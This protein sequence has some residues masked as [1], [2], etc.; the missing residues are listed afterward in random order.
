[1]TDYRAPTR[2]I[3]FTLQEVVDAGRVRSLP[4]CEEFEA[5]TVNAVIEE[6]GRFASEVLGPL[7]RSG[8]TEGA[9]WADGEVTTPVGFADA[10][11]QFV[12]AGWNSLTGD[13]DWGGMG[14][15]GLLGAAAHELWNGANMSFALCPLLS[16]SGIELLT[17][18]GSDEQK[19]T[20]LAK[21]VSGEWPGTMDL[22]EPQAGSDLGALR[23]RAEPDGEAYRLFGQKI[24]ITW[25]E[26]DAADNIVHLVLA[27]LPDAPPGV[28]GISLFLVPKYLVNED[29]GIGERNDMRCVSIEHKL[30]IH[31]SPTCTMVYGENDGAVGYLVG[32]AHRGLALMFTMM[33]AARQK[34]GVQALGVAERAYQQARDFALERVQGKPPDPDAPEGAA[35]AYHPDVRRMLLDMKSR[36]EAMRAL[37]YQSAADMD[38]GRRHPDAATRATA[39]ARADLL[40]PVVKAWCTELG[41]ELA[42]TGIQVYGGMG[43]IEETGAAQLL[44]DVRI[45]AIYEGTNGIQANDLVG[46]KLLR[47]GGEAMRALLDEIDE[48]RERL[49][50]AGIDGVGPLAERLGTALAELRETTQHLLDVGAADPGAAMANAFNY[51]MQVGYVLGGWQMARVALAAQATLDGGSAETDFY[52]NKLAAAR[53]YGA[54][55]LPRAN[56]YGQAVTAGSAPVMAVDPRGL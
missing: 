10:Y 21:M 47:D 25:G 27:R 3:V 6:A 4:G 26:H 2:D 8:D 40:I 42:S 53:F 11:R 1:M 48:D 12:A 13:P 50:A 32:E 22:T 16:A 7:N 55:V 49:A 31:A 17:E 5:D 44:R 37:C 56:G 28:Q 30:G 43:F 24:F 34:M 9:R 36:I 54:Q 38:V 15:P 14:M 52:R 29:G 51:L 20:Y 41:I 46:R 19:Q 23:T 45:A 33:N 18:Y 35:I 39:Q